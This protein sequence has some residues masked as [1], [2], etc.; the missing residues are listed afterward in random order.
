MKIRSG[1]V[2]NSS[3][4]SFI[5][6]S[7]NDKLTLT[8]TLQISEI[9]DKVI[10]NKEELDEYFLYEYGYNQTLEE[11]LEEEYYK[12]KYNVCMNALKEGGKLYFGDVS[13]ED[14]DSIG[15][16]IYQNGFNGEKNFEVIQ[17]T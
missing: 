2:S 3:S 14:Y 15:S 6:S 7:K 4:S 11:L 1:F 8:L 13:N 16:F 10:A 12:E 5:I 17:D 9:V